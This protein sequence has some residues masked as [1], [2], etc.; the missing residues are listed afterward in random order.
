MSKVCIELPGF[1]LPQIQEENE[2][3]ALSGQSGKKLA[4]SINRLQYYIAS[5]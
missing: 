2:A 4:A 3:A 5:I 1:P